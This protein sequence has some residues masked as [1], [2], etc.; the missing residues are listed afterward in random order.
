MEE[1]IVRG[2]ATSTLVSPLVWNAAEAA[3]PTGNFE[4]SGSSSAILVRGFILELPPVPVRALRG[5][6][7][8]DSRRFRKQM[9]N[10]IE[11]NFVGVGHPLALMHKLEPGLDRECLEEPPDIRDVFV[12]APGISSVAPPR[13]SQFIDRAQELSA[14]RGV[15]A[16]FHHRE[17]RPLV[18]LDLSRGDGRAPVHR[19]REIDPDAGLKFP[20]P[21]QRNSENQAGRRDEIG[22]RQPLHRGELTPDRAAYSRRAEDEGQEYRQPAAAPNSAA[23][24]APIHRASSTPRSMTRHREGTRK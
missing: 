4:A 18:I 16:V 5:N 11:E 12:N 3:P 23:P 20:T 22:D 7:K 6:A 17:D 24:A 19:R 8:R 1:L 14:V 10:P 13:M 21:S 2:S 9:A 15:D